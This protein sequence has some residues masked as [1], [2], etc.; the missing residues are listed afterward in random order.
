MV[1]SE[2]IL[3][4]FQFNITVTHKTADKMVEKG[5]NTNIA[6][7]AVATPFPPLNDIYADQQWPVNAATAVAPVNKSLCHIS[8]ANNV[9]TRPF[10]RS[11][12]NVARPSSRDKTLVT[13]E[14]PMFPLPCLVMSV[15]A[16]SV[17][18]IRPDGVDATM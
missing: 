5:A 1:I 7:A 11:V 12:I 14:A 18:I 16:N 15:S 8:C 13:L 17:D 10:N 6:P 4:F 9:G 2:D 3:A